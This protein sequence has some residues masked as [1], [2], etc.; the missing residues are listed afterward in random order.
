MAPKKPPDLD[1]YKQ[2]IA[3]YA[4]R[5]HNTAQRCFPAGFGIQ[6]HQDRGQLIA[7]AVELLGRLRAKGEKTS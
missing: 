3:Q 2:R 6:A 1:D 4:N 7:L 5:H